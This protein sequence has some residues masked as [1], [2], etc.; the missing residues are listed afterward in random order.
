[1]VGWS[2]TGLGNP[3]DFIVYMYMFPHWALGGKFDE[4]VVGTMKCHCLSIQYWLLLQQFDAGLLSGQAYCQERVKPGAARIV[5]YVMGTKYMGHWL[6]KLLYV[7]NRVWILK[8]QSSK[9]ATK[10]SA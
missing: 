6:P 1:M 9:L 3:A 2:P 10:A 8:A 4:L 7:G 5:G